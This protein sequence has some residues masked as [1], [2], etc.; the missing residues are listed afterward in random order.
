[1]SNS[2]TEWWAPVERG[3]QTAELFG[4]DPAARQVSESRRSRQRGRA[5]AE[6]ERK[7][8][9][10]A[11]PDDLDCL[12]FRE[13]KFGEHLLADTGDAAPGVL[14]TCVGDLQARGRSFVSHCCPPGIRRWSKQGR[15][16]L[17]DAQCSSSLRLRW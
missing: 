12:P 9:R 8:R 5:K 16:E 11:L 14:G 6:R 10:M 1:M 4:G 15:E 3:D 17:E 7:R 13:T 2:Q